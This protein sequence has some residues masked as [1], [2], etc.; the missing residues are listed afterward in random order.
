MYA[1]QHYKLYKAMVCVVAIF[2]GNKI[3]FA[4]GRSVNKIGSTRTNW[5]GLKFTYFIK[6]VNIIS[7]IYNLNTVGLT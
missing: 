3:D 5:N 2:R 6:L 4:I 7:V 1:L